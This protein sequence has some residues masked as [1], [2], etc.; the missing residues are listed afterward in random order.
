[1]KGPSFDSHMRL[2]EFQLI[3]PLESWMQIS[4]TSK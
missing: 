4:G 3:V 2:G 1:M